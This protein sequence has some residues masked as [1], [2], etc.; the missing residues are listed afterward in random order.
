[1]GKKLLT[2]AGVIIVILWMVN[3]P[4]GAAAEVH[5]FITALEAFASA[6]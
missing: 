4:S 3:N 6:I 2:V 1:M 5:K